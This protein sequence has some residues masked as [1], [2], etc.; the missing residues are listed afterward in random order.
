MYFLAFFVLLFLAP[1]QMRVWASSNYTCGTNVSATLSN[2]V[3]TISGNGTMTNY[4]AA[5]NVPWQASV[6]TIYAVIIEEGVTNIG[7]FA[8]CGCTKLT[9]VTI[10][11]SVQTIG[12]NA[13]QNCTTM[14]E[15]HTTLS[16]NEWA[17]ITLTNIATATYAHPFNASNA[18]TRQFFFNGKNTATTMLVFTPGITEI[19]PYAF[20][21]AT[22]IKGVNL[23][24]SVQT[25]GAH[26]FDCSIGTNVAIN[27]ATPPT[28]GNKAFSFVDNTVETYLYL[29]EG[30]SNTYLQQPWYY[31]GGTKGT[32]AYRVGFQSDAV[33]SSKKIIVSGQE[34]NL[35]L[36]SGK[37]G[38]NI[39]WTLQND[40]TLVLEGSGDMPVYSSSY[41]ATTCLPWW[42][43]KYLVHKAVIRGA[44]SEQQITD[45]KNALKWCYALTSITVEQS[46]IPEID[47]DLNASD[48][49]SDVVEISVPMADLSAE[50]LSQEPWKSMD[51]KLSEPLV[52]DETKE[53]NTWSGYDKL[54]GEEVEQ[55]NIIRSLSPDYYNTFCSPISFDATQVTEIFGEGTDIRT[56]EG[57]SYDEGKNQ[58]TLTFSGNSLSEIA[59]GVP[60][61]IRPGKEVA[62]PQ[63]NNIATS[64]LTTTAQKIE[65]TNADFYGILEPYTLSAADPTFLFLAAGNE[66][67]WGYAGTL[68]GMR[69]Y[70]KIKGIS[71]IRQASMVPARMQ[72][73][74][75]TI[76]TDLG[77]TDKAQGTMRNGK[78]MYN[79]HLVIVHNGKKYNL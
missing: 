41:T 43:F 55:L 45:I 4:T 31:N 30:A 36:T 53:I 79:G 74:S 51:I 24:N 22:G 37:C 19:K 56:L 44:S 63:F 18:S 9:S 58:L 21:N 6:S 75:K 52:I 3:L 5:S 39:T 69:A 38:E 40:G 29:P 7:D 42:R 27:R 25:I 54:A 10:P 28:T 26:A 17:S 15:V 78:Y 71:D 23:P 64:R 73:G 13:F 12:K 76:S 68:K 34:R 14:A 33:V 47:I 59:A 20:Y 35:Y 8:F 46:M 2:N 16:M 67:M 11:S 77:K 49:L 65:T 61:L 70:F 60:Y 72:F 50:A 66:L 1:V 32:G 48:F 62:N 57:S